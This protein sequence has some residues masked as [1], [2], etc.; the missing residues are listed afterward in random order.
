MLD[1]L[2]PG[3]EVGLQTT[4]QTVLTLQ[5]RVS[6][7]LSNSF[8]FFSFYVSSSP[9][10]FSL[11]LPSYLTLLYT[12]NFVFLVSLFGSRLKTFSNTVVSNNV[13]KLAI[14]ILV[15][16]IHL[17][18]LTIMQFDYFGFCFSIHASALLRMQ[19]TAINLSFIPIVL[20]SSITI[21]C[22]FLIEDKI[23]QKI[24]FSLYFLS[25]LLLSQKWSHFDFSFNTIF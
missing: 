14:V 25:C 24:L 20:Q 9:H 17:V 19:L 1:L 7:P 6:L 18:E 8:I 3:T 12:Y 23:F 16:I 13:I 21:H 11:L 10:P 4:L 2:N 22:Y 15:T 5:K